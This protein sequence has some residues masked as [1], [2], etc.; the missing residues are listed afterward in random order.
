[1]ILAE[2]MDNPDKAAAKRVFEAMMSMK[3]IDIAALEAVAQG[4]SG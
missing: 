3:K 1:M 4:T 2:N